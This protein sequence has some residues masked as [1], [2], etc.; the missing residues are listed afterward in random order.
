MDKFFMC[1]IRWINAFLE[2]NID[3]LEFLSCTSQL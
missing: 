2:D 3:I 1:L